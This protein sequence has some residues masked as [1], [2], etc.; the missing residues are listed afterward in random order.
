M[1]IINKIN[2]LLLCQKSG[3]NSLLKYLTS[4]GISKLE[5]FKLV[6]TKD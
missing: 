1:E 2:S 6:E 5:E 3:L 4:F